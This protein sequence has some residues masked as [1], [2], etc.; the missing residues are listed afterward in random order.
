MIAASKIRKQRHVQCYDAYTSLENVRQCIRDGHSVMILMRG[1]PG[2]GKTHLAKSLSA[3]YGGVV[4]ST[5]DFFV[6]NGLYQFQS[7]RLEEYHKNNIFRVRE[8]MKDGIKLIIVDNTNIFV[9]HMAQ[10]TF[11]A[12]V[13]FYEIFVVEPETSWKYKVEECFRR[14]IHGIEIWKINSMLQ[15]LHNQGRPPLSCLVGRGR[16]VRLEPPLEVLQDKHTNAVSHLDIRSL[17]LSPSTSRDE[18]PCRKGVDDSLPEVSIDDCPPGLPHPNS[19][20]DYLL[21]ASAPD[22]VPISLAFDRSL[23]VIMLQAR[24]VATQTNEVIVTLTC[25]GVDCPVDDVSVGNSYNVERLKLFMPQM[26]DRVVR[27]ENI[28]QFSE[29]DVLVAI[30]PYEEIRNLS[31]YWE[32]LGLEECVRL[33]VDLGAYVEWMAVIKEGAFVEEIAAS[34][35][36]GTQPHAPMP[37]TDWQRIAEQEGLK[38]YVKSDSL[39]ES[40]PFSVN[41]ITVT[42]GVDLLQKMSV[43]FG[44]GVP[45]EKE[46]SVRLPL[47]LLEQLYLFWQNNGSTFPNNF[48]YANDAEIAATL[49]EEEDAVAS[50]TFKNTMTVAQKLHLKNLVEE[51]SMFD[52]RAV[53]EIFNDNMYDSTAARETLR[54]MLNLG[55]NNLEHSHTSSPTVSSAVVPVQR[56]NAQRRVE[57]NFPLAQE[58]ARQY[59]EQANEFAKKKFIELR[60][61]Q[62]YIQCGNLPV[63]GYFGQ[64]ARE[65]SIREKNLRKQAHDIIIKANEG[66]AILD[67]HLLSERDAIVLLKERL[68]VL[69]RP[70]SMRNGRSNQRLRV[71]TGYGKNNGGRSVIK[72][73]VE[74]YLKREGYFYSFANMGEVVIQCK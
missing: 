47:W 41:E 70:L 32:M 64:L 26:K 30:F 52:S 39:D 54:I 36:S 48:Q 29:L 43:L 22:I 58:R 31:H 34:E 24:E 49:Q 19:M 65:Y 74:L 38:E 23:H 16:E 67:L 60:K 11:H 21:H 55:T 3:E 45:V 7:E 14:N 62:K 46:S 73:A 51:F 63:V 20:T 68:S 66:S 61:V 33:F 37:R 50:N 27:M 57:V 35:H 2:S 18:I 28:A 17:V 56:S 6:E 69:D 25:A 13:H 59:Q 8:A 40:G 9:N 71:I 10:Y 12:V 42:L 4:C 5:D 72:P 44:E 53:E 15:S 1:V